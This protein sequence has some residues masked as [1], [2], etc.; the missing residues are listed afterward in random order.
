MSTKFQVRGGLAKA[1]L[2]E[3]LQQVPDA[4][5]RLPRA[6]LLAL[7]Q[8]GSLDWVSGDE[9]LSLFGELRRAIGEERFRGIWRTSWGGWLQGPVVKGFLEPVLQAIGVGPGAIFRMGAFAS[10]LAARGFGTLHVDTPDGEVV[11]RLSGVPAE[12]IEGGTFA[13]MVAGALCS[14][15]DQA[16][17]VGAV[18]IETADAPRGLLT[19]RSRYRAATV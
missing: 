13:S 7:Q 1:A 19:I 10:E 14:A 4:A 15:L 12:L 3:A 18:E 9:F 8:A 11:L 5:D 16:G 6:A 17:V 2:R